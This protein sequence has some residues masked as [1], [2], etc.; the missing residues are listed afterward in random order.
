MV[1]CG[2]GGGIAWVPAMN[3]VSVVLLSIAASACH[4]QGTFLDFSS[5]S[6]LIPCPISL[7]RKQRHI[8]EQIQPLQLGNDRALG[9]D[10][11]INLLTIL[12]FSFLS[13]CIF[14]YFSISPYI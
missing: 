8:K 5:G 9:L 13:Q 14:I 11:V 10:G 4:L 12:A 6:H 1:T 3:G 7:M 2:T